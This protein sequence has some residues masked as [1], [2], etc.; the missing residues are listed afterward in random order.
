MAGV[1][2]A[3]AVHRYVVFDAVGTLMVPRPAAHIVYHRVGQLHGSRHSVDQVRRRFERL[4]QLASAGSDRSDWSTSPADERERWRQIVVGVFDDVPTAGDV[5]FPLL[6]QHFASPCN[7]QVNTQVAPLWQQLRDH[8]IRIAIASN[9]DERLERLCEQLWPLRSAEFVFHSARL[10]VRKPGTAFFSRIQ[11]QLAVPC[12]ALTMVGDDLHSD[13]VGAIQ[14]GWGAIWLDR[15]GR[16]DP[17]C[18][19]RAESL[20]HVAALLLAE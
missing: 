6:W 15:H 20:G 16:C 3:K 14:A 19:C 11:Q 12:Q 13:Y 1:S 17:L 2:S 18:H 10:G 7:W 5:I 9:F 4:V 8:G